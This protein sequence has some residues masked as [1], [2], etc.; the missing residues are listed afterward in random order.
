MM[1]VT[2][3]FTSKNQIPGLFIGGELVKNGLISLKGMDQYLWPFVWRY[4]SMKVIIWNYY[5]F[6]YGMPSYAQT[7]QNLIAT[8][9]FDSSGV[10]TRLNMVQKERSINSSGK[11]KCFFTKYTKYEFIC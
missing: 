7:Y 3:Y 2:E 6:L 9:A 8:N 4:S 10:M 1:Q 11:K 5:F